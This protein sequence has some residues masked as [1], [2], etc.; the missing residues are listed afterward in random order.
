[1]PT[2][3]TLESALRCAVITAIE[4]HSQV[5]AAPLGWVEQ[6]QAALDAGD[7]AAMSICADTILL[8]HSQY[9]AEFDVKGWLFDLRNVCLEV[10]RISRATRPGSPLYSPN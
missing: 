1:M 3:T 2:V 6:A 10:S 5:P 4:R 7:T 8:A 9:R